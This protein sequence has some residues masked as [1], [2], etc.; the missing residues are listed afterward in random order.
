M[1]LLTMVAALVFLSLFS[2]ALGAQ[3]APPRGPYTQSCQDIQMKGTTLHAKCLTAG[4]QLASVEMKNANRCSDG[5]VNIN[6]ILSCQ[7][8]TIPPG[9]Y[10][11]SCNDVH[12]QGTTLAASCTDAKGKEMKAELRNANQCAGDIA[13]QAGNLRCVE[14][15]KKIETAQ[16]DSDKKKKKHKLLVF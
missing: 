1:R 2:S 12:L 16:A 10:L 11:S 8:G 9:S 4:G 14:P 3:T 7:A 6:G 15:G 13:N 5:V